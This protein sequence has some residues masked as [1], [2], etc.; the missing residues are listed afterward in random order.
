MCT[1]EQC[2]I[3]SLKNPEMVNSWRSKRLSSL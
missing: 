2:L 3:E 1:S